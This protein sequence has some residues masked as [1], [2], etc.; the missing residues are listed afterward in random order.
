VFNP[1]QY[2][3]RDYD[4]ETGLRYYRAR[5]YDPNAGRFLSED[6]IGFDGNDVNFYAYV[7]NDPSNWFDLDGMKRSR[8]HGRR[9]PGTPPI[10]YDK[11]ADM[12]VKHNKSG[13]S[14]EL[15][16]CVIFKES[17]FNPTGKNPK[18]SAVGLMGVEKGVA[19]DLKIPYSKLRDPAINITAG[20]TYLH[21]R[22]DWSSPFGADGDVFDGLSNYGEGEDYAASVLACEKC[23][24]KE[25]K[26]DV[27]TKTQNCLV[28]LHQ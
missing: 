20:T 22:I 17:S 3:G 26:S 11:I 10:P 16:I 24:K 21:R 4:P 23:L 5:Y 12:V 27:G 1:F 15:I 7:N 28:P 19:K 25:C 13:Q 8:K 14:T 2:T 6:P 18:S 9:G